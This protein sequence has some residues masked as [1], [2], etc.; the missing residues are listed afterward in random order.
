ML[1][2][3]R[4]RPTIRNTGKSRRKSRKIKDKET[5]QLKERVAAS[6]NHLAPL[7]TRRRMKSTMKARGSSERTI[8]TD[9]S[10]QTSTIRAT[11]IK[12]SQRAKR[13]QLPVISNSEGIRNTTNT[14]MNMLERN[15]IREKKRNQES[16][17]KKNNFGPSISS[18]NKRQRRKEQK[19]RRSHI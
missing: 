5:S 15:P 12:M 2:G 1:L 13:I 7:E 16:R 6:R 4:N 14:V 17:G 8:N 3:K 18:R 19:A 10:K 9:T 11:N